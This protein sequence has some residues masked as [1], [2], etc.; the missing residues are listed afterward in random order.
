[1]NLNHYYFLNISNEQ[2]LICNQNKN[3]I[4]QVLEMEAVAHRQDDYDFINFDVGFSKSLLG[5]RNFRFY[6][7][8][9]HDFLF[10]DP[11]FNRMWN[12]ITEWQPSKYQ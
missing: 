4:R 9:Y 1:M 5:K 12:W 2:I 7:F 6:S 10:S 8:N 11:A 3:L